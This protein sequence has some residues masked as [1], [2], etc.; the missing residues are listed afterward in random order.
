MSGRGP[1]GE[2]T[3]AAGSL[4]VMLAACVPN[5]GADWVV[6]QP[7]PPGTGAVLHII[8]TVHHL[9][10][11]GGLFV[12]RD[13]HGV[14]YDPTNLPERFRKDGM[15][16]EVEAQRR[17]D[18]ASIGMVGPIIALRRIRERSGGVPMAVS[19][20]GTS[21]RLEDLVGSGV[22]D[23]ARATLT[24]PEPG[25]T[26]GNGSCNS[27]RG[28][29]TI[30]GDQITFGALATTRMACPEAVMHQEDRY[31]SALAGAT[32]FRVEGRFLYLETA[33]EELPL[34]FVRDD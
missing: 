3:I 23:E 18:M 24:F 12:I 21:W 6:P 10:I 22:L 34:R 2:S 32:T 26:L 17:D 8:G 7:P 27:F 16:V 25:R 11:E 30:E 28:P 4:L 29:V 9:T 20:W 15:L 19:L 5:P 31:L 14:Q 13:G 1:V 33:E